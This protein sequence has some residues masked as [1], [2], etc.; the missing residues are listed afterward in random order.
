MNR[1]TGWFGHR[2][3]LLLDNQAWRRAATCDRD[4][5]RDQL[6]LLPLDGVPVAIG[7]DRLKGRERLPQTGCGHGFCRHRDLVLV[8]LPGIAHAD[9]EVDFGNSLEPLFSQLRLGRLANASE[10]ARH[11][12]SIYPARAERLGPDFVDAKFSEEHPKRRGIS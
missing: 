4:M 2:G 8:V 3:A 7:V 1:A 5:E 10:L 9:R 6:D 11:E 12:I